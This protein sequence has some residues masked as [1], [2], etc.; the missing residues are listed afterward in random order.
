MK[1][2]KKLLISILFILMI[3][4]FLIGLLCILLA[5][6]FVARADK[7]SYKKSRYYRDFG[8]KYCRKITKRQ[9][10]Q[11]YNA[12]KAE[13]GVKF[14]RSETGFEYL[15]Y[16]QTVYIFADCD[17]IY[18]D[19]EHNQWQL[20][21]KKKR[22]SENLNLQQYINERSIY[23]EKQYAELPVKII[24]T[25]NLIK[26]ETIEKNIV[27][28][29]LYIVKNCELAFEEIDWDIVSGKAVDNMGQLYEQ[30]LKTPNLVGEFE[31]VDKDAIHWTYGELFLEISD[32]YIA[33]NV[34]YG[35]RKSYA[36]LTHWHP[37]TS[38]IY[39]EIVFITQKGNAT[40]VKTALGGATLLYLGKKEDC[41]YKATKRGL[42]SKIHLFIMD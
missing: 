15:I 12:S 41:P 36:N 28:E 3:P 31:L 42:F 35:R 4:L 5:M 40:V 14:V 37:E 2:C 11:F 33:I 39:D 6:P 24:A 7:K 26:N 22:K 8:V 25:R 34:K 17:E 1:F 9:G 10:Y 30:L 13:W 29:E 16:K 38:E 27:P 19:D 32:E 21:D 18:Y 20:I 23:I